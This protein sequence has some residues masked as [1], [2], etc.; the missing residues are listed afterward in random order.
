MLYP[1][2]TKERLT[3]TSLKVFMKSK[4]FNFII[5]A[6]A[7]FLSKKGFFESSLLLRMML[8]LQLLLSLMLQLL[9]MMLLQLLLSLVLQLLLSL[10]LQLLLWLMLLL[11]LMLQLLTL[12]LMLLL[13]PLFFADFVVEVAVVVAFGS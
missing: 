13:P 6:S 4:S 7:F 2:D 1:Q 5:S 8:S 12:S 11:S 3:Q 10:M 9:L